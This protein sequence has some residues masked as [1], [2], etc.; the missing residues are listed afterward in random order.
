MKYLKN[1]IKISLFLIIFCQIWNGVFSILGI[2]KNSVT[3]FYKEPKNSLDIAY[4][5]GSNAYAHFNTVLA[6]HE[7]G[8]TTGMLSTDAQQFISVKHLIKEAQ[9][10]QKPKVYVIDISNTTVIYPEEG[11]IRRV[12]D[13]IK[14]STNRFEAVKEYL[15]MFNIPKEEHINY[16]F[17]FLTYHSSY[18][19]INEYK[20]TRSDL[21]KGYYY[22]EYTSGIDPQKK[23]PW[24]K[25]TAPLAEDVNKEFNEL[26]DYINKEKLNVLFIVS[27]KLY[28]ED[29]MQKLNTIVEIC[30]NNNY[31]VLNFNKI[32]LGIDYSHDYYNHAHLNVYG[33][34]KFTTYLGKYLKENYNLP[35]NRGGYYYSSWEKEYERFKEEYR[36][37]IGT[38][39][40]SLIEKK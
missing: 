22:N 39:F 6:F 7:Y 29:V 15:E 16:Y 19:N 32:D 4:F 38:G 14:P 26:I 23:V 20:F 10:R 30:E 1:L 31:E 3:Y 37:I 28:S 13:S 21:F 12:V 17:S 11:A 33:A 34:T 5:G 27:P 9:K 35:D 36:K 2:T 8:F 40:E 25:G 24:I 18:K